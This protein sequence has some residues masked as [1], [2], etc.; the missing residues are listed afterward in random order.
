MI[1]RF[2]T[3]RLDLRFLANLEEIGGVNEMTE[4]KET[5]EIKKTDQC[6]FAGYKLAKLEMLVFYYDFKFTIF[7]CSIVFI[8]P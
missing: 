6:G 5:D 8:I 2:L 4:F 3:R 1:N 7:W